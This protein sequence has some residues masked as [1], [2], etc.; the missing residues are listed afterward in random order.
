MTRRLAWLTFAACFPLHAADFPLLQ[1]ARPSRHTLMVDY[2]L[3][4]FRG[5]LQI[6]QTNA[7]TNDLASFEIGNPGLASERA[8][9][10]DLTGPDGRR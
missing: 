8:I 1:R 10:L 4:E 5:L 6:N 2:S 3:S 7:T 9:G